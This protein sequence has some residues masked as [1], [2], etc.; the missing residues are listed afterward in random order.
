MFASA[1][2]IVS[3]CYSKFRQLGLARQA[4]WNDRSTASKAKR[5]LKAWRCTGGVQE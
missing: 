4:T 2:K 5:K 3:L 1:V